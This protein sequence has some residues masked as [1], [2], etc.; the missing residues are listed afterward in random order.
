MT[1]TKNE[2]KLSGCFKV[3]QICEQ[4]NLTVNAKFSNLKNKNGRGYKMQI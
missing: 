4:E 1:C 3:S 2:M